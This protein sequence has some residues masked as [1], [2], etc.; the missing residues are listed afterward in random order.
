MFYC[1]ECAKEK[2]YPIF[3]SEKM[4]SIGPCEICNKVRPCNDIRQEMIDLGLVE[5]FNIKK[6]AFLNPEKPSFYAPADMYRIIGFNLKQGRE[7]DNKVIVAVNYK[8]DF[9]DINEAREKVKEL[10]SGLDSDADQKY[11][12]FNSKGY[13]ERIE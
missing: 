8:E 1:D 12:L 10:R 9:T 7:M 11:F 6:D 3:A 5:L 13:M 2:K 4:K